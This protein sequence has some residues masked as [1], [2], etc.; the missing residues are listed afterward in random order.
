MALFGGNQELS[1]VIKA[2]DEASKVFSSVERNTSTLSKRMNAASG[3]S[4]AF[5]VALGGVTAAAGGLGLAALKAA[6]GAEQTRVAFTTMLGSAEK[7][8]TF[9]RD[10]IQF[11]K[12]T[13]FTLQGLETASKQL[14]AYGFAQEE[15]LP[16][17]KALGNVAAGVGMDKLPNLILAFG[18]VR[19]ATKLTGMELRQFTE[20]GVPLLDEL[21]KQMNKPVSAIQEMVSAGEIGFPAVQQAL[22]SLTM[23]GGRFGDLMGQQADTLAGKWSNLQD[24]W[25][26]FLRGQGA[27]IIEWAK[28][29]VDVGINIVTNV[30]PPWVAALDS[31]FMF[32]DQ[33]RVILA[34]IAG[35]IVG[36]LVPAL[37]A[38]A[39]AFG[40]LMLMLAPFMA[41][42]AAIALVIYNII[43]IFNILKNDSAFVWAGIKETF[44]EGVNF[45]AGLAESFANVWVKAV[46]VVVGALNKIKFSIPDWVPGVGGKSFG[47][48]IP[49]AKEITLPRFEFGGIVPGAR[50]QAVPIMAHGGER[51]LPAGHAGVRGGNTYSVVINNPVV[52]NR[53]DAATL[54]RQI[55][56]ALR[57]VSRGHKLSTI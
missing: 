15:V 54:R 28:A 46:N 18:Q 8:D 50:G 13:P 29:F 5:A 41:F 38:A 53:D 25:D 10:L 34:V 26:I 7:A 1:I 33:H 43:G 55:E 35:I 31:L 20:A 48:S 45:L 12:T 24:A 6:A 44:K 27:K 11:A 30:L 56:Q 2:R 19:A 32:L 22:M 57:D 17:L 23:E 52:S 36:A 40:A 4:A 16:N 47:I 39:V 51:V 42:G 9:I 14:L 21:A 3:A 49:L 37:V